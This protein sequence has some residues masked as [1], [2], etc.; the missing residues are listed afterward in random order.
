MSFQVEDP[1]A[2]NT[3]DSNTLSEQGYKTPDDLKPCKEVDR[4]LEWFDS[5]SPLPNAVEE[6]NAQLPSAAELQNAQAE[7]DL[8]DQDGHSSSECVVCCDKVRSMIQ[9]MGLRIQ[10]IR[11]NVL[12]PEPCI[13]YNSTPLHS[14]PH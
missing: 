9:G 8:E 3:V 7:M 14:T 1:E 2:H 5:S 11:H 6:H 4:L 13:L 10:I 12:N